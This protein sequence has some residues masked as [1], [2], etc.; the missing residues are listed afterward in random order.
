MSCDGMKYEIVLLNVDGQIQLRN[1]EVVLSSMITRLFPWIR[2][3]S[4]SQPIHNQL[5]RRER[6]SSLTSSFSNGAP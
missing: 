3:Q 4:T 5:L 1:G 6:V 2:W